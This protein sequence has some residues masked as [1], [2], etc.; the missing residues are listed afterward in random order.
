MDV[1]TA[2]AGLLIHEVPFYERDRMYEQTN[3]QT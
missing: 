2:K 3:L 1:L